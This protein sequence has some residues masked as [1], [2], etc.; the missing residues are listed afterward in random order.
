MR[1]SKAK[2][3]QAFRES[4]KH[5]SFNYAVNLLWKF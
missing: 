3:E 2:I 5:A 4:Y 1:V